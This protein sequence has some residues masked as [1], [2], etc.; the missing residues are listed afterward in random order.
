MSRKVPP[1]SAERPSIEY[2]TH[3]G[4]YEIAAGTL[5]EI[6]LP[7]LVFAPRTGPRLP[8]VVLGHGYLQ[9]VDRYTW[10]LTFLASWG[11][12]AAAPATERGIV[13]S[14]AGLALD[15]ARTLDRLADTKLNNGRVTVDRQRLAV[16][17]HGIGGGA[18]VLAAAASAP[19]VR[20]TA[21]MFATATFPSAVEAAAAVTTPS[22]HLVGSA[23][24]VATPDADGEA[25][26][27]A[28]AGPVQ[29]RR[30][31][32]ATHLGI[33]EGRHLTSTLLGDRGSRKVRRSVTTAMT[34]FLLC[35]V[36]GHTQLA[37]ALDGT[38]AG[39]VP[40]PL[41]PAAEGTTE[42]AAR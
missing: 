38:I 36:A 28:W 4:P 19:P 5:D 17:G 37:E 30:I 6:G 11:F 1:Y 13:P 3:R 24:T 8:A 29:L 2:L 22:L 34:A 25:I 41:T 27:R 40:V 32:G 16:I 15:M 20:A 14:H 9:P 42:G 21:T 26:A 31:K 23:D 39:T 33:V 10:L 12:V 35:H 18:A 7:G